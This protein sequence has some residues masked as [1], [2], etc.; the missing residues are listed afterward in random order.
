MKWFLHKRTPPVTR[1]LLI[2]SG[3]REETGQLIPHLRDH[4]CGSAPIDLFTYL[5]DNPEGLGE[6]TQI[7][8][9]YDAVSNAERWALLQR[10]RKEKHPAVA[11]ICGGSPMLRLWKY[12]LVVMLP[13]KIFLIQDQSVFFWL[14][15]WHWQVITS[16]VTDQCRQLLEQFLRAMVQWIS[17]PFTLCLLL[18]FAIKAHIGRLVRS[19]RPR[20][21]QDQDVVSRKYD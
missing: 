16:Y 8:R 17:L 15:F 20:S 2:E 1:L 9:S 18:A 4:V 10:L 5:P 3:Y 12:V 7:W 13:S 21:R 14:D 6:H 19:S 11:I